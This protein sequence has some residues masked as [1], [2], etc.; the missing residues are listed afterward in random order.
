VPHHLIDVREVH[1]EFSAGEFHD[2]ARAAAR[3]ILAVRMKG[4][5][6]I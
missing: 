2:L 4:S 6:F 3:D 5:S 1:E